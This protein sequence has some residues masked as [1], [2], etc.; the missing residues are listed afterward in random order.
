MA[1]NR[2]YNSGTPS[3]TDL[4]RLVVLLVLMGVMIGVGYV[5]QKSQIYQLG[6]QIKKRE[7]YLAGLRYENEKLRQQLATLQSPTVLEAR[8]RELNLGLVPVSAQH[9]VF[10][11]IEPQPEPLVVETGR[12]YAAWQLRVAVVE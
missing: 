2:K 7:L 11:L 10:T 12:E 5:W 4:V 8:V 1:R 3:I 6:Q 9:E